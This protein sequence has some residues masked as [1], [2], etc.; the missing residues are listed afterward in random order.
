M[1]G[2]TK[3][4]TSTM[5]D[6]GL[7]FTRPVPSAQEDLRTTLV[8]AQTCD[9]NRIGERIQLPAGDW[10]VEIGRDN[11]FVTGVQ[12]LGPGHD[13]S[14][15]DARVSGVH[16]RLRSCNGKVTIRD[17]GSKYGTW[18][19]GQKIEN[20][21][22]K[23]VALRPAD[24]LRIGT[25]IFVSYVEPEVTDD[26]K[27]SLIRYRRARW[28]GVSPHSMKI[29]NIFTHA[30]SNR[31]DVLV[32][33]ESGSGKSLLVEQ[34]SRVKK[35]LNIVTLDCGTVLSTLVVSTLYGH[36]SGSFT[37]AGEQQGL[38]ER[39]QNNILFSDEVAN[40]DLKS[41]EALL[42]FIE[43]REYRKT[44]NVNN[45]HSDAMLAFATNADLHQ[46][47]LEGRFRQDLFFRLRPF[48]RLEISPL[49]ERRE[50]IPVI[51]RSLLDSKLHRY[52]LHPSLLETLM[53][54]PLPGNVRNLQEVA[55]SLNEN[56]V[57]QYGYLRLPNDILKAL[58]LDL[59][60][61]RPFVPEL[62]AS[63]EFLVGAQ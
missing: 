43:K 38:V 28:A 9:A 16:C 47:V 19:N 29:R 62:C 48:K 53:L 41:Q 31:N 50:D 8:I 40:L 27:K 51:F 22:G 6:K 49:R 7:K 45:T 59:Q 5:E 60:F 57:D 58:R 33:G 37:D 46:M 21:P 54:H 20:N 10:E 17:A 23:D 63:W 36:K 30:C 32:L 39:A 52:M 15:G 35:G 55:I 1:A 2:S 3:Q 56:D 13:G 61:A 26:F 42:S 34:A 24:I 44:G 11:E 14:D 25:T 4:L 18:I 12:P